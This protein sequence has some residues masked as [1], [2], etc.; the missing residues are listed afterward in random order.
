[1]ESQDALWAWVFLIAGVVLGWVG[2]VLPGLPG[3]LLIAVG[4]G[5]H[6][7]LLPGW[8]SKGTVVVL[9]CLGFFS[10][11]IE[12]FGG[13]IG[14][15]WAGA[16]RAG[17]WG[18]TLGAVVG[19]LFMPLGLILGPLVGALLGE[20]IFSART[21]PFASKAAFGTLLGMAASW[22]SR[23]AIAAIMTLYLLVDLLWN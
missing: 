12:F 21:L 2:L 15:K 18:A 14:A 13:V 23:I 8:V 16:T 11:A 7:W 4:A 6:Y 19:F 3:S 17:L 22:I 9:A 10:I 20:L 1:M 5:L